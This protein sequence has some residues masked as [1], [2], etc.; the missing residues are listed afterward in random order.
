[1]AISTTVYSATGW[2]VAIAEQTVWGTPNTTQSEFYEL[3]VSEITLPDFSGLLS[4]ETKRSNGKNIMDALD[5]FRSNAGSENT[6]TANVVL[7]PTT[8]PMLLYG[9]LQAITSEGG[10]DPFLK[11]FTVDGTPL[12]DIE[13][14]IFFTLLVYSPATQ[15]SI[16]LQDVV[17]RTFSASCDAGASGGRATGS[18]T[19]VNGHQP[20]YNA[21]ATTGSW[22]APGVNYYLL[23]T[24]QTKTLAESDVVLGKYDF[25]IENGAT[26]VGFDA[27]GDA[28]GFNF[29]MLDITGNV[30]VKYDANTKDLIDKW[31]L[32]PTNGSA[33]SDLVLQHGA[34][35]SSYE[36]EMTF[37]TVLTAPPQPAA[38]DKGV[39]MPIAW[40]AVTEGE[41]AA[42][43]IKSADRI[44]RAWTG[45]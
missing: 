30:E 33:D 3:H 5:I 36:W 4:D 39:F 35:S 42:A 41:T 28:Q 37:H 25:T 23:Q 18:V 6:L 45:S 20:A 40:R 2:R 1:M 13:P 16:Q 22:V 9:S 27:N 44:D 38:G 15:E 8:L 32:S 11:T 24:L 29:P 34:D 14:A 17:I 12:S 7:T 21:T 43:T 26:R 10:T 31:F 19:F